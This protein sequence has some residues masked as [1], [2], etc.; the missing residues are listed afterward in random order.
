MGVA[1]HREFTD[2]SLVNRH[3]DTKRT[4]LQSPDDNR[5]SKCFI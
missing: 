4:D 2:R 1:K 5:A 3:S